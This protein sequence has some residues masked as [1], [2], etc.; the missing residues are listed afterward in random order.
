MQPSRLP[1]LWSL[2]RLFPAPPRPPALRYAYAITVR[3]C[4]GKEQPCLIPF[5]GLINHSGGSPHVVHFSKMD[6]AT[7]RLR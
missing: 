5:V 3:L 4:G 6:E 7:K 2:I 1:V